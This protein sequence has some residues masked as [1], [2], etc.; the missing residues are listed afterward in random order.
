MTDN[1]KKAPEYKYNSAI[2]YFEN[3]LPLDF[4]IHIFFAIK[5]V[6]H[7]S[8]STLDFFFLILS[9]IPRNQ[10]VALEIS[11]N[12]LA[13]QLYPN[14]NIE[15]GIYKT[16]KKKYIFTS[17]QQYSGFDFLQIEKR[18]VGYIND[19]PTYKSYYSI[20]AF[21]FIFSE[22]SKRVLRIV[23]MQNIKQQIYEI[24][25]Q[26]LIDE[27]ECKPIPKGIHNKKS[28][29]KDMSKEKI[30]KLAVIPNE[31]FGVWLDRVKSEFRFYLNDLG[32]ISPEFRYRIKRYHNAGEMAEIESR[33]LI[34]A[35][36]K[37]L[38]KWK[39]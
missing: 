11:I 27:L 33:E 13:S 7:L 39:N 9:N 26:I 4:T 1:I 30:E 34:E 35:T 29:Q 3:H 10:I 2:L 22:I 21:H 19:H 14:E 24:V 6:L 15:N 25:K 28:D 8:K 5:D 12:K 17:E 36:N 23:K 20:A 32:E 31:D 37:G 16:K 18:N 38:N